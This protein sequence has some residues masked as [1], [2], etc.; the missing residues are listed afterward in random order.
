MIRRLLV[1][2]AGG[3]VGHSLA[4]QARAAGLPCLAL[5]RAEAPL[6]QP[7]AFAAALRSAES[8][9]PTH[10]VNAAAHTAVDQAEAEPELAFRINA[11]AV[12]ELGRWAQARGVAVV[13]FS[14]DYV[15]TRSVYG[16]SKLAGE[17]L[18]QESAAEH[19]VLRTRWVFGSHGGNFLKTMLGLAQSRSQLKVVNDQWGSPT[20]AEWLAS[21][22]LAMVEGWDSPRTA[23]GVHGWASQGRVHWRDYAAHAIFRAQALRPDLPWAIHTEDQIEGISTEAYAAMVAP[24]QLADRP[25]ESDLDCAALETNT[26]LNRP[27]W[28]DEVEAFLKVWACG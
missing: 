1:L 13:H 18:L 3:Q 22:V 14:T 23:R 11:E 7:Q 8:F 27:M 25:K 21:S 15:H 4:L 10:V 12:G 19:L 28:Q 9:A 6:D 16:R 26:G 20:R 24:K 2:G 5:G 17:V